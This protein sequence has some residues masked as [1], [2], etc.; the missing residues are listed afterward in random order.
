MAHVG[1]ISQ[2]GKCEKK[3]ERQRV[4]LDLKLKEKTLQVLNEFRL[5]CAMY[6]GQALIKCTIW[7]QITLLKLQSCRFCSCKANRQVTIKPDLDKSC[8]VGDQHRSRTLAMLQCQIQLALKKY[9][10]LHR[11]RHFMEEVCTWFC[12]CCARVTHW[13][14]SS[15]IL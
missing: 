2:S 1:H 6:T 15:S 14:Q 13:L 4:T 11:L 12:M 5:S 10:Y 7:L 8:T 3:K 9:C